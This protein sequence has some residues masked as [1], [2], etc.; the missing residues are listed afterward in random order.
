[1][2]ILV[3]HRGKVLLAKGYGYADLEHKIPATEHTVFRLGSLSK[4]FTAAAT[5][6]LVDQGLV[7]L[8]DSIR[9]YL[10]DYPAVGQ[11][12]TVRHLLNHTSGLVAY[13]AQSDYWKHIND[14]LPRSAVLEWFASRDLAF[15]PGDRYVYTNTGYFLLGLI[16]EQASGES[17][18]DYLRKN[19]FDPVK[20]KETYY[21][22]G[23]GSV[24]GEAHGY[25]REGKKLVPARKLNTELIFSVGALASSVLDIYKFHRALRDGTL[26]TPE[27]YAIMTTP[28]WLNGGD[29]TEYGMGFHVNNWG[30]HLA[31]RHGGLVFGFKTCYYYYPAEDLTII[32]LMN[33]ENSEYRP[34]QS[35]IARLFI[36]DLPA[37]V[38]YE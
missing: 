25:A 26:I 37:A 29:F 14:N 23:E 13:T 33:T 27:S 19:I 36:P 2:S 16:I 9:R 22:R 34:I 20:L 3:A 12:I 1:M 38:D 35:G 10:P 11:A 15:A 28:A 4:Q 6:Q 8:D 30:G 7:R 5:M 18:P 21:D 24:S 32:I 31:F 17:F